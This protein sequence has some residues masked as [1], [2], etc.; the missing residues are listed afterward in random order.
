MCHMSYQISKKALI[1]ALSL[2]FVIV[3]SSIP[4]TYFATR[5]HYINEIVGDHVLKW[6]LDKVRVSGNLSTGEQVI[7]TMELTFPTGGYEILTPTTIF[8]DSLLAH[9][10]WINLYVIEPTGVVTTALVEYSVQQIVIFSVSGNWTVYCNN[11]EVE[12]EIQYCDC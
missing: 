8:P 6:D 4:I 2:I 3:A 11:L 10:M 7:L 5:N 1:G 12:V 9:V